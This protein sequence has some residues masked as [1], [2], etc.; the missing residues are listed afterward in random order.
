MFRFKRNAQLKASGDS[1]NQTNSNLRLQSASGTRNNQN[2]ANTVKSKSTLKKRNLSH[3]TTGSEYLKDWYKPSSAYLDLKNKSKD[4]LN[5]SKSTRIERPCCLAKKRNNFTTKNLRTASSNL[6][7]SREDLALVDL[8][9]LPDQAVEESKP[10]TNR[11][12][13]MV[14]KAV[15]VM[16]S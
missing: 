1:I 5:F 2:F 12:K 3:A 14:S 13:A 8:D 9:K 10:E 16:S 15:S 6:L 4:R 7:L 11:P